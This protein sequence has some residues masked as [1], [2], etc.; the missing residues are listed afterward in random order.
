[1]DNFEV[2]LNEQLKD[3]DFKR[4][5]EASQQEFDITELLISAR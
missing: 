2:F 1:M 4:E 5:L 3:A